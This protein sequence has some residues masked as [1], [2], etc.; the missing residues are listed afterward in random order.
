MSPQIRSIWQSLV[1][2]STEQ[3]TWHVLEVSVLLQ[4]KKKPEDYYC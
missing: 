3:Q 4:I 2:Q 1:G